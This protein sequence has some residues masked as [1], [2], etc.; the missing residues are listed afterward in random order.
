MANHKSQYT[1][2][3]IHPISAMLVIVLDYLWT[4]PEE[5]A[6][7]SG[8]A[9]VS[10]PFLIAIIASICFVGVFLVQRFT[11][12]DT[13]GSSLAKAFVMSVVAAVPL[14]ITGTIVGVPLLA[15]AGVSAL[16]KRGFLYQLS[17]WFGQRR[18]GNSFFQFARSAGSLR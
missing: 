13:V 16:Q 12:N 5:G 7:L 3:P 8:V 10:T 14:P 11:A 2:A 4:I 17:S 18:C 15:W 1:G 6:V 9:L